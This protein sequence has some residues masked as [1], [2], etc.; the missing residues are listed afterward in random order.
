MRDEFVV[1]DL[2]IRSDRR[3]AT[4]SGRAANLASE[5]DLVSVLSLNAGCVVPFETL[6]DPVRPERNNGDANRARIFVNQLGDNLRDR[7]YDPAWHCGRPLLNPPSQQT[8]L[9]SRKLFRTGRAYSSPLSS[10]PPAFRDFVADT[11]LD[12]SG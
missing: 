8:H 10:R 11:S 3:V 6:L 9:S 2:V 12:R 1:V 5:R 4:V 7:P